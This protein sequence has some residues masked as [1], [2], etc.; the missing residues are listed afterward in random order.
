[1]EDEPG[2]KAAWI[3][4]MGRTI[5]GA[6]PAI[7]ALVYF[8][9]Y[10]TANS[11]GWYDWRVDTSASAYEAFRRVAARPFF[12]GDAGRREEPERGAGQPGPPGGTDE[13]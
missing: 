6:Y 5:K 13:R 12:G 1:M 2:D 4:G 8:D 3:R 9:A 10:A 7:R 11:G